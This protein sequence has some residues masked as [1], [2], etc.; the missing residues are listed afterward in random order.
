MLT[1]WSYVF[2]ALTY[3]KMGYCKKDVTP[4]LTHRSYVFLALTYRKMGYCKKDVTALLKHWSYVF[5]ALTYWNMIA[6][7]GATQKELFSHDE[8]MV[9]EFFPRHWP[10]A[11]SPLMKGIHDSPNKGL[12]MW[13]V[14]VSFL[15]AWISCWTKSWLAEELRHLDTHV[16][17]F[18][19]ILSS[20]FQCGTFHDIRHASTDSLF[21]HKWKTTTWN[22]DSTSTRNNLCKLAHL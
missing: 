17:S 5:L 6:T 11:N 20:I 10:S 7:L 19:R 1:H 8:V 13:S 16:M 14:D 22:S 2:L 4:L 3:R 21:G 12:V 18:V 9:W 15:L